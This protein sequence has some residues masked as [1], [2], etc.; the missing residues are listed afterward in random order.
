MPYQHQPCI[1]RD[2][3]PTDPSIE[4]EPPEKVLLSLIPS[5]S[6]FNNPAHSKRSSS[7]ANLA[8]CSAVCT[9]TV[10]GAESSCLLT[11]PG[12]QVG[13]KCQCPGGSYSR[14]K[15]GGSV[16]SLTRSQNCPQLWHVNGTATEG[17]QN[18]LS[19]YRWQNLLILLAPLLPRCYLHSSQRG[20]SLVPH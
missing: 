19:A 2:T 9:R 15:G 5:S 8:G 1:P 7:A 14:E 18:H 6:K 17:L 3:N 10:L 20:P 16:I 13:T 11:V 4:L 12:L